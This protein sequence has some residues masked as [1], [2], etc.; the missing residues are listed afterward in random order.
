M[1]SGSETFNN[2]I[3]RGRMKYHR[4][5]QDALK[6]RKTINHKLR[7]AVFSKYGF[8]CCFC[9]NT[10]KEARIQIDHIDNNP[11]NND[12]NNLQVACEACNKGKAYN[13][14]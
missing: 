1:R 14:V 10:A 5:P 12:L 7:Y 8:K 6:Q 4:K 9:G 2:A 11:C 3:K 13:N